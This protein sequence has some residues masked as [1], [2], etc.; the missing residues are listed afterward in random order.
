MGP[1]NDENKSKDDEKNNEKTIP[2]KLYKWQ[3]EKM[4]KNFKTIR[5][6]LNA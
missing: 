2:K 5:Y 4:K 1:L 6:K 3:N